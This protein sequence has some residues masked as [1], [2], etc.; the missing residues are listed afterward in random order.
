MHKSYYNSFTYQEWLHTARLG[1]RLFF[2]LPHEQQWLLG[3]GYELSVLTNRSGAPAGNPPAILLDELGTFQN[4]TALPWLAL[5]WRARRI[6]VSLDGQNYFT[7]TEESLLVGRNYSVRLG[8]AY[9]LGRN[10]DDAK[11][12]APAQR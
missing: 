2:S 10:P 9:R 7:P 6:T 11:S 4:P 8:I 5:G 1:V 12:G 3:L